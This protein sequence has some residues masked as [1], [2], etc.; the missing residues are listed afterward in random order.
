M[1]TAAEELA[2]SRE[3]ARSTIGEY[4]AGGNNSEQRDNFIKIKNF[5]TREDI[6]EDG[7]AGKKIKDCGCFSESRSKDMPILQPFRVEG[8]ENSEIE[9]S[10]AS[11]RSQVKPLGK[12]TARLLLIFSCQ[13]GSIIVSV[14]VLGMTLLRAGNSGWWILE[15]LA[16]LILIRVGYRLT[17]GPRPVL[18]TNYLRKGIRRLLVDEGKV[19][20]VF[21]AAIF[22]F[23]WPLTHLEAAV[24]IGANFTMQL[25][26][27]YY[28]KKVM[29]ALAERVKATGQTWFK[30]KVII[31]GTGANARRVADMVMA[32]PELETRLIGFLDYRKTGLWSYQD[33]PL[34]G[35]PDYL[36]D[37]I[38][39]NQV[40]AVFIAVEPEDLSHTRRLY[41]TAERMGITACLMPD[42]YRSE[43]SRARPAYIN[44]L[45]SLIYRRVPESQLGLLTKDVIDRIGA[46]IGLVFTLP[47]FL[48]T[49]LTIKLESRGPVFFKQVR[50]GLNGRPFKLLK[51]RTMC[52]DAENKKAALKAYNEMSGPVFKIKKD[53]RITRVG[54]FLRKYS[55]DEIPQFIN[56]LKGDM[57][58]VGPRPPLPE[59]V[60]KYEPWQ[61]RKL[62]VKPGVTC[63]W[64][65]N[66]RNNIDFEEWMQL[67]LQYIDNWSLWLDAKI[68][69]KTIPTVIRGSGA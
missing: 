51:F 67:D 65:V 9:V 47:I 59:E 57:S 38:A 20:T 56:V 33:I 42:I 48:L 24:F 31:V 54:R 45:P 61:H 46:F 66:G 30:K 62:S 40:D 4:E 13:T 41:D 16:A 53:P 23:G 55:I 10:S 43:L 18:V 8:G 49:A 69:A 7:G 26:M 68:L 39:A 2:T 12:N 27:F 11:S 22:I 3:G 15:A 19:S 28:A 34:I 17:R 35:H 63:I 32:S 37:I 58:L 6:S 44:G 29:K 21:L 52:T 1:G 14:M 50:S 5:R 64:Q 36:E 60:A 25:I